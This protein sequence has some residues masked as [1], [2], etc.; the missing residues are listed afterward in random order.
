M[1]TTTKTYIGLILGLLFLF[2]RPGPAASEYSIQPGITLSEEYNDNIFLTPRNPVRDYITRLVP[3]IHAVYDMPAWQWSLAYAYD[4]RYYR[5]KSRDEDSTHDLLFTNHTNLIRDFLFLDIRDNYR[6]VSLDTTHDFTRQSLFLNQT[7]SNEF[8]ASPY[9]RFD[10]TTH[11]SGTTGYQYRNLWYE[12]RA[13]INKSEHSGFID[14]VDELSLRTAL[15]AGFRYTRNIADV[16]D[17]S[18][19]YDKIDVSAGPR[20]EYAEGCR[21]WVILGNSTFRTLHSNQERKGNQAFWDIGI[22]HRFIYSTLSLS[23]TLTYIDDPQRIQRREDRYVALFTKEMDRVTLGLTA[24]RWEYRDILT[25]HLQNTRNGIGGALTYT[26]SGDLSASYALNI[27]RYEDNQQKT[28]SMLYLNVLRLEYAFPTET[29]L[30]FNYRFTHGYSP[31]D[32]SQNYDNNSVVV[33]LNK[34][35]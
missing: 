32:F 18:M 17:G 16:S 2:W 25:K 31:D 10:L 22:R 4:Y 34:R 9:V 33:E 8:S 1:R 13:A 27:D 24:G 26:F 7:D 3:S 29:R 20:Y 6:R 23:A 15:M 14:L 35:F 11:T 12:D 5:Y 19:D 30:A 21:I 28:Y